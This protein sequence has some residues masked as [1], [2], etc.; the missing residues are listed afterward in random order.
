MALKRHYIY[1]SENLYT[2]IQ[3]Y[4]LSEKAYGKCL[5]MVLHTVYTMA[6]HSRLIAGPLISV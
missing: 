4:S 2:S 3:S 5:K 1:A 6:W